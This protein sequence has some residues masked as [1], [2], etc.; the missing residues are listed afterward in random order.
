MASAFKMMSNGMGQAAEATPAAPMTPFPNAVRVIVTQDANLQRPVRIEDRMLVYL[1]SKDPIIAKGGGY[2][3]NTVYWK[4]FPDQDARAIVMPYNGPDAGR[5]LLIPSKT[6]VDDWSTLTPAA[7]ALVEPYLPND[8]RAG[9]TG[10]VLYKN[11]WTVGTE[12]PKINF[13][14]FMYWVEVGYNHVA[15]GIQQAQ[16]RDLKAAAS[17]RDEALTTLDIL[18]AQLVLLVAKNE[19]TQIEAES[20][21]KEILG[22]FK[23]AIDQLRKEIDNVG[24]TI[25]WLLSYLKNI[26]G[27]LAGFLKNFTFGRYEK[28]TKMYRGL[29]DHKKAIEESIESIDSIPKEDRIPQDAEDLQILRS[30]LLSLTT[31]IAGIDNAL[32]TNQLDVAQI[33]KDAGLS[34]LGAWPAVAAGAIYIGRVMSVIWNAVWWL[35]KMIGRV[36]AFVW[37]AMTGAIRVVGGQIYRAI[38]AVTAEGAVQVQLQALAL[39][40]AAKLVL[41]PV[42][43]GLGLSGKAAILLITTFGAAVV[44]NGSA[45]QRSTLPWAPYVTKDPMPGHPGITPPNTAPPPVVPS[46]TEEEIKKA[47]RDI[48]KRYTDGWRKAVSSTHGFANLVQTLNPEK[49][50]LKQ[51]AD[52]TKQMKDYYDNDVPK[53]IEEQTGIRAVKFAGIAPAGLVPSL[54]IGGSL[55]I[56]AGF[57]YWRGRE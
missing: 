8:V 2:L 23:E 41:V 16:N 22:R 10:T 15:N 30:Y 33:R 17:F 35:L 26:D 49:E 27:Q 21:G 32:R 18:S 38:P 39:P 56:L 9:D 37:Q 40:R 36:M 44:F 11:L 45:G 53:I 52:V 55:A 43:A 47:Q 31:T 34:G 14:V 25:G 19:I 6:F 57:I 50:E 3:A 48:N 13:P 24:T 51:Y 28:L 5:I 46:P 4:P 1:G 20:I 54:L 7:A 12:Y 29:F 42:V